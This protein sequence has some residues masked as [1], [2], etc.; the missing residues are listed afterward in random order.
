MITWDG[1]VVPCCFD[2]DAQHAMGSVAEQSFAQ[3]WQSEAYQNFR[4]AVLR[5]RSE[6][7]MCQNCSEGVK[8]WA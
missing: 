6:I 2:K 8:V 5:S 1:Q 4:A 3:V 7:E